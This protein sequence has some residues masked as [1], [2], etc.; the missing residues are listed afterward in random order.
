MRLFPLLSPPVENSLS[1]DPKKK[2]TWQ[3]L[4]PWLCIS[5]IIVPWLAVERTAANHSP[6]IITSL[7]RGKVIN[8]VVFVNKF[9]LFPSYYCLLKCNAFSRRCWICVTHLSTRKRT[10]WCMTRERKRPSGFKSIILVF[11]ARQSK[12]IFHHFPL[13]F[14]FLL[15]SCPHTTTSS[16]FF[17]F[18]LP[19][20]IIK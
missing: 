6:L 15:L 3:S 9:H 14:P 5:K 7:T 11:L 2:K 1:T 4:S 13:G 12:T 10:V 16:I 18:L 17:S 20:I 8:C 19:S